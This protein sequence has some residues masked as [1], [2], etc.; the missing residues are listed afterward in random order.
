MNQSH[1]AATLCLRLTLHFTPD[2]PP[3]IPTT[4]SATSAEGQA[5]SS[6]TF[7]CLVLKELVR[8]KTAVHIFV[9]KSNIMAI[10][11]IALVA[12]A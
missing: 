6:S 1:C 11:W 12:F 5:L 2:H 9:S 7:Q 10:G 4:V 3:Q 8:V